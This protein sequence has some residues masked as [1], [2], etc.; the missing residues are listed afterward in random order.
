MGV[1]RKK[2]F[3]YIKIPIVGISIEILFILEAI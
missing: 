2:Y 3:I 1:D